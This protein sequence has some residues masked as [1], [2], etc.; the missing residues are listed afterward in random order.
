MAAECG[1]RLLAGDRKHRHVI[2]P[3]VVEPGHEVRSTR[4]GS[5]DAYAELA[6]ELGISR[7]H[8]RGHFLVSG[9]DEL[10]LPP[11]TS[12]RAKHPVDAITGV[13]EDRSY[14]PG[15]ESLDE[16]ITYRLRHVLTPSS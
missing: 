15:V 7:S 12:E 4:P 14:T 6:R 8:E 13:A 2:E 1:A 11:G 16:E 10:N 3:R 9:L 5:G